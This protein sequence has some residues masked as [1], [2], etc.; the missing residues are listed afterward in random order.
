MQDKLPIAIV[1]DIVCRLPRV[2]VAAHPKARA[3]LST[4]RGHGSVRS[5]WAGARP[6]PAAGLCAHL[7]QPSHLM[8]YSTTP[9]FNRLR[10]I[11][12]TLKTS[13]PR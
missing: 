9:S 7:D 12:S 10:T 2:V 1:S 4:G 3:Q 11:F 8:R 5:A 6:D 13:S